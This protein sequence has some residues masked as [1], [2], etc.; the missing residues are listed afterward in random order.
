MIYVKGLQTSTSDGIGYDG[1]TA[2]IIVCGFHCEHFGKRRCQFTDFLDRLG[3]ETWLVVIHISH[4]D[5][6]HEEGREPYAIADTACLDDEQ[7]LRSCLVVQL[8]VKHQFVVHVNR[9]HVFTGVGV[10]Q[11]IGLCLWGSR[12]ALN[13][14]I[15]LAVL[16]LGHWYFDGTLSIGKQWAIAGVIDTNTDCD[17]TGHQR[18]P[19][20]K[21]SNDK[22]MHVGGEQ[23][24]FVSHNSSL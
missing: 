8:R 16:I 24:N 4:L 15:C 18:A 13:D 19:M 1:I 7:V 3:L 21:C 5:V 22:N 9:E 2:R 14:G 10:D 11:M 6:N 23:F 12:K 20:I 17:I